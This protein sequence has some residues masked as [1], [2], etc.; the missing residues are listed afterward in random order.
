M[1]T[2]KDII[3]IIN[4]ITTNIDKRWSF[5]IV[6]HFALVG[7]LVTANQEFS[8]SEKAIVT[9]LYSS[10]VIINCIGLLKQYIILK[11]ILREFR[12]HAKDNPFKLAETN[13]FHL[14]QARNHLPTT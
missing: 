3:D 11:A 14:I 8:T 9:F 4:Q 6:I 1:L 7:W 13:K 5:F 12:A 2:T 10:C